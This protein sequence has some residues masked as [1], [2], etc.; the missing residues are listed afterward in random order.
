[1]VYFPEPY[2]CRKKMMAAMQ[3]PEP[4]HPNTHNEMLD[5]NTKTVIK[6]CKIKRG[7]D[8]IFQPKVLAAGTEKQFHI[9]QRLPA[10]QVLYSDTG[11]NGDAE[12]FN[13]SPEQAANSFTLRLGCKFSNVKRGMPTLQKDQEESFERLEQMHKDLLIAAF[14]ADEVKCS[15]KVKAKAKALKILKKSAMDEIMDKLRKKGVP[16]NERSKK[17]KEA[18]K[19]VKHTPEEIEA[20]ALHVYLE[21]SHDAGM[22]ETTFTDNGEEKTEMTLKIKRKCRGMRT[23]EE[24]IDGEIVKKRKLVPTPPV[25]HKSTPTGEY[26]EKKYGDYVPRGTLLQFKVR[27]AFYSSPMSYGT[28]LTF[29]KDVTILCE[30]KKRSRT[31]VSKPAVYFEDQEDEPDSKRARSDSE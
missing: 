29:D 13:K 5:P 15:G 8:E 23:V 25:F 27:R 9:F 11:P 17:A 31:K 14:K 19:K 3:T 4:T 1:M 26:F 24:N 20:T 12:K 7:D 28:N 21:D 22:K 2:F 16:E 6:I 30:N 18:I 10:L